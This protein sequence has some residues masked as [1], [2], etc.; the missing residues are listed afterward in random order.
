MSEGIGFP[1]GRVLAYFLWIFGL[2]VVLATF[3]Y[4]EFLIHLK[5]TSWKEIFSSSSFLKPVH[6]GGILILAGISGSLHDPMIA[7]IFG[8]T[9]FLVALWYAKLDRVWVKL[10]KKRIEKKLFK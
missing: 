2:A 5:K 9:A 3:S 1:W 4:H 7:G 6:I 8:V 10:K